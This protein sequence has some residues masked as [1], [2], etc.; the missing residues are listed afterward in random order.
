MT[1]HMYH[2]ALHVNITCVRFPNTLTRVTIAYLFRQHPP[3]KHC[4]VKHAKC[5]ITFLFDPM[6]FPMKPLDTAFK[7]LDN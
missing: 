2:V 1:S 4:T 3:L 7:L 5:I 6:Q